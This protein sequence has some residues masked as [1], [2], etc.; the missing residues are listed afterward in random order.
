MSVDNPDPSGIPTRA[1][2]EAYVDLQRALKRYRTAKDRGDQRDIDQAHGSV[3]ESVLT[4]YELL[5]PY[6]KNEDA[7][8]S[9]WEGEP[10]RYKEDGQPPDIEDGKGILQTQRRT[11]VVNKPDGLTVEETPL[12][13]LHRQLD[14]NENV[15]IQSAIDNGDTLLVT[16]E[17]YQLGLRNLDEWETKYQP[18]TQDAGGFMKGVTTTQYRRARIDMQRLKRAARELSSVA[19]QLNALSKFDASKPRTDITDEMVEEVEQWRRANLK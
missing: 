17:S 15:R 10:P 11:Q 18:K 1:L 5:R 13:E 6:L 12:R 16:V 7:I 3:Q 14:L 2:H 19:E 8:T 4:F 9:Y